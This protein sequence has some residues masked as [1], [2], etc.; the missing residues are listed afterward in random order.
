MQ[1]VYSR[2]S[3]LLVFFFYF[4]SRLLETGQTSLFY[5]ISKNKLFHILNEQI[6]SVRAR[7]FF[8]RVCWSWICLFSF[9]VLWSLADKILGIR[10]IEKE[11]NGHYTRTLMERGGHFPVSLDA[12]DWVVSKW[13]KYTNKQTNKN[14]R[15]R[16]KKET[17]FLVDDVTWRWKREDQRRGRARWSHKTGEKR[18]IENNAFA[19]IWGLQSNKEM[20]GRQKP[21][22]KNKKK[23]KWQNFKRPQT[24]FLPRFTSDKMTKIKLKRLK[25]FTFSF[26]PGNLHTQKIYKNFCLFL[27]SGFF[28]GWLSR[29]SWPTQTFL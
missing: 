21:K 26:F 28:F 29:A 1:C 22:E 6:A 12:N 8:D 11:T 23:T 4:S 18:T 7:L 24:L 20:D 27:M 9:F 10:K 3:V 15:K 25:K 5:F 19:V 17:R 13:E 16:K 2:D 14:G